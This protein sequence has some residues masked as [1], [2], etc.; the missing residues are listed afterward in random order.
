M[1]FALSWIAVKGASKKQVLAWMSLADTGEWDE[2]VEAPFSGA[3]IGDWYVVI[4]NKDMDFSKEENLFN[5]SRGCEAIGGVVE[6]H[7]MRCEIVCYKDA[8]FAWRADYFG[9]DGPDETAL[10]ADGALPPQWAAI[11]DAQIA[12]QK[13]AEPDVD[14]YFDAPLELAKSICGFRHDEIGYE[15]KD[16]KFT[17][18]KDAAPG[19]P[20]PDKPGG[21]LKK[22]FGR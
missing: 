13:T 10:D 17:A 2:A 16:V 7:V 20:T 4:S 22:L 3:Q 19:G 1:G 18:L 21:L 8:S 9:E 6:E 5:L 12:L 11:R 15:L 14:H